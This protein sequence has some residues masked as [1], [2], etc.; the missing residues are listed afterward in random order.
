MYRIL[1]SGLESGMIQH[2]LNK[3]D[4]IRTT[5]LFKFPDQDPDQ[6]FQKSFYWY[7]TP[8][9]SQNIFDKDLKDVA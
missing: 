8:T 1:I 5:V 2:I 9:Q 3:P 4:W 6:D 7:L